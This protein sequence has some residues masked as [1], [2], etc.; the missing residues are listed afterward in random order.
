MALA[1]KPAQVQMWVRV[2]AQRLAQA[3]E[4]VRAREQAPAALEL[5]RNLAARTPLPPGRVA[6]LRAQQGV[7]FGRTRTFAYL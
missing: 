1:L 5:A 6:A 2:L 3:L 4:Q 7:F